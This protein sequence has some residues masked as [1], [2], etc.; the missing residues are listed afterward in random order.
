LKKNCEILIPGTNAS[1]ER[2]FS[3]MNRLWTDEKN[4]LKIN[5]VKTMITVKPF[6]KVTCSEFHN[7]LSENEKLQKEIHSN[8][9]YQDDY[10]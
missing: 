6:F 5:T 3:H 8:Q 7:L 9:K 1:V 2:V 4:R 10:N